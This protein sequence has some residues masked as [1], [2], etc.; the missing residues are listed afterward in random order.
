MPTRNLSRFAG[1]YEVEEDVTIGEIQTRRR[2]NSRKLSAQLRFAH[3]VP[4]LDQADADHIAGYG[5]TDPHRVAASLGLSF[6]A[7]EKRMRDL[8]ARNLP[9]SANFPTE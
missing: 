8:A 4:E 7:Y 9:A 3:I 2:Q 5:I 1:P 6:P